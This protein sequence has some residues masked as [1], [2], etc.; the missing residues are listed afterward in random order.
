MTNTALYSIGGAHRTAQVRTLTHVLRGTQNLPHRL[1]QSENYVVT[2]TTSLHSVV[3][4]AK[5]PGHVAPPEGPEKRLCQ[6]AIYLR[7]H[8]RT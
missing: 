6:Y 7:M 5:D 4:V 8:G 1:T 3:S 2:T